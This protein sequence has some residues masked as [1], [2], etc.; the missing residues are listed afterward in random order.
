MVVIYVAL[1]WFC[2]AVATIATYHTVKRRIISRDRAKLRWRIRD[3][4]S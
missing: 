3:G 4:A 2:L 1:G